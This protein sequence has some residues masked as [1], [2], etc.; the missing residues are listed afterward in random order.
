[1]SLRISL[2]LSINKKFTPFELKVYKVVSSI[3][4]GQ[5][6]AYS[7]VAKKIG[8]PRAARAVGNA[9]NKN[10]YPLIIPCHRVIRS[11]GSLGGYALGLNKKKKLLGLER[12]IRDTS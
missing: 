4:M 11:N 12:K 1:M 7:W 8:T 6:R 3:P 10:P 5:T 2:P 9:L